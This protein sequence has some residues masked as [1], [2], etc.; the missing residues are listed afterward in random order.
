MISLHVQN[1]KKP[2][3][4]SKAYDRTAPKSIPFLKITNMHVY[5]NTRLFTNPILG[6]QLFQNA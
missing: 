4:E 2:K 3:K 1:P 6:S 5:P